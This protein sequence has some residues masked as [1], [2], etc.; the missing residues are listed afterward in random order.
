M[1]EFEVA[2]LCLPKRRSYLILPCLLTKWRGRG[3]S[4]LALGP[5]EGVGLREGLPSL[6][7]GLLFGPCG[8]HASVR[9]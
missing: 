6:S 7:E 1:R 2:E 8:Q 3:P 5:L 9:A 4:L